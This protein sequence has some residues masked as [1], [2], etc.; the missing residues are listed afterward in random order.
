MNDNKDDWSY[1]PVVKTGSNKYKT[2]VLEPKHLQK[3]G[4]ITLV[5]IPKIKGSKKE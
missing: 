2:I 1:K 3:Y 4:S 5:K